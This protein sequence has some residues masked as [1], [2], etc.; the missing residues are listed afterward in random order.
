MDKR[1]VVGV[2]L[3]QPCIQRRTVSRISLCLQPGADGGVGLFGSKA[4]A[5]QQAGNVQ[6][7]T[8]HHKG[9]PSAARYLT[10]QRICRSGEIRHTV[11]CF[12]RQEVQQVMR[13][14]LLLL[15]ARLCRAYVQAFVELH[16]IGV[17]DLAVKGL[18]QRH[19]Q[20]GLAAGCRPADS[21]NA[22]FRQ[23]GQTAF[24]APSG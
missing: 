16:R 12:R 1:C 6:P 15:L 18:C 3:L 20:R 8:A 22:G 17:D 23:V 11:G 21:D 7:C 10:D 14:P 4:H 9:Q 13:Y 24:P 5:V 2:D 19:A